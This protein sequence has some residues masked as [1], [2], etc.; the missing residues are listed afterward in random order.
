MHKVKYYLITACLVVS[1]IVLSYGQKTLS[2]YTIKSTLLEQIEPSSVPDIEAYQ[3]SKF[4]TP[5]G[6]FTSVPL[7]SSKYNRAYRLKGHD[8]LV[9]ISQRL[10]DELT[11]NWDKAILGY[12]EM[13]TSTESVNYTRYEEQLDNKDF[14]AYIFFI[15]DYKLTNAN[16]I[17]YQDKKTGLTL[18]ITYISN[19]PDDVKIVTMRNIIN[20]L[21]I[22]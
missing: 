15:Q 17:L 7:I 5:I 19:S 18:F 11:T 1:A 4:K 16:F 13:L 9:Q 3:R 10:D 14:K 22:E 2:E 8:D 21:K 12:S 6:H 20:D